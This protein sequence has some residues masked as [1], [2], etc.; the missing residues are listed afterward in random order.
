MYLVFGEM[1]PDRDVR[2]RVGC[3]D[4]RRRDSLL[5]QL[6]Y[7]RAGERCRRQGRGSSVSAT[8]TP[9]MDA[10][11]PVLYQRLADHMTVHRGGFFVRQFR[12]RDR[13]AAED[14][15]PTVAWA[16]S[17]IPCR[18][19]ADATPACARAATPG[20]SDRGCP[21]GRRLSPRPL[22]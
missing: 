5:C 6:Y 15:P 1:D 12:P 18:I 17:A 13:S 19:A 22:A 14:P 10:E 3:S 20:R 7:T 21:D 4:E 11:Q 16:S 9:G 2:P 8:A